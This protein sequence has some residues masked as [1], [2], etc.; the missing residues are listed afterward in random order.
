MQVNDCATHSKARRYL[1]LETHACES[2]KGRRGAALSQRKGV[3]YLD[4]ELEVKELPI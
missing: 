4:D 3:R 2:I 1:W